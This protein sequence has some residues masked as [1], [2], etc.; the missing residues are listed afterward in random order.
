MN[1]SQL[2]EQIIIALEAVH[3]N[4]VTATNLAHETATHGETV[5]ENKYDT[6]S[7]EAS[8]LAHGQ[9]KRVAEYETDLAAYKK[10][11]IQ[12]FTSQTPV[13]PGALVYLIEKNSNKGSIKKGST[14]KSMPERIKTER[15]QTEM[16]LFLGPAA[17]GLKLKMNTRNIM[18]ITLAAPLGK[19]LAGRYVGEEVKMTIGKNEKNYEIV[20][21]K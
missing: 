1:K 18:I 20:N 15:I 4:A 13:A 7:L 19:V 8:Y 3:K 14:D 12:K 6:F 2:L 5:A 16:I 9:A 21:I 11:T 17:G 10:F